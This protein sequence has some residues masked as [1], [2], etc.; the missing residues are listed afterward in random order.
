MCTSLVSVPEPKPT[1]A[2]IK[3]CKMRSGNE[4]SASC[5]ALALYVPRLVGSNLVPTTSITVTLCISSNLV[6]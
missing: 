3:L 2:W 1:P 5:D 6:L 4:I